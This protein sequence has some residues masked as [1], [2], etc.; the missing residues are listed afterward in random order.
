MQLQIKSHTNPN[1]T[2]TVTFPDSGPPYCTCKGY[3]YRRT[4]SHIKEAI[5]Q[6]DEQLKIDLV[7]ADAKEEYFGVRPKLDGTLDA[8]ILC[9]TCGHVTLMGT[10]HRLDKCAACYRE[11]TFAKS[12]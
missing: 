6:L 5:E 2:Y 9:P 11:A 12:K 8:A 4:C 1:V 3:G 7:A 10:H